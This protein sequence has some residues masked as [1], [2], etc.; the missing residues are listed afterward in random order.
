MAELRV[1]RL[2]PITGEA[3]LPAGTNFAALTEFWDSMKHWRA[4]VRQFGWLGAVKSLLKLASSGRFL[5]VLLQERRIVSYVWA[6]EHSPRYRIER[7]ACVLGPLMTRP[8][9]RRQGLATALLMAAAND[10]AAQGYR[11]LYID[12]TAVNVASQKAIT[13]AGF[14]PRDPDERG[15]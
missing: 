2:E 3:R 5:F 10:L 9:K 15:Q 6:T 14:V 7:N 8:D 4:L 12:T 11:G 1:Y 13:R